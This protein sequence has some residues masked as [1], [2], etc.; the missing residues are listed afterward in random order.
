VVRVHAEDFLGLACDE[1]LAGLGV[2]V[3]GERE[4]S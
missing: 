2:A 4:A 3:V 1:R